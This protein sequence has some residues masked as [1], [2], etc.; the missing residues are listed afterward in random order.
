MVDFIR[1]GIFTAFAL[2]A[3]V[4]DIRTFRIPDVLTFPCF[5][6]ILF[7]HLAASE[8]LP[9]FLGSAL[10]GAVFFLIIRRIT[11][12]LGFGDVKFAAL[13]GLLCG[14]PGINAAFLIAAA[15]GICCAL[16]LRL[17]RGN[18]PSVLPFAPFL[19]FGAAAACL[20]IH[21]EKNANFF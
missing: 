15:S 8:H 21:I 14:F 20:L 6:L 3:S 7:T 16:L 19:S 11:G 13:M 1:L 10:Y 2:P 17:L 12:G 4:Y 5:V 9:A 18:A